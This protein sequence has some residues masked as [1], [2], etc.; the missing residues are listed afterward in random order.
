MLP[1][2]QDGL[3]MKLGLSSSICALPERGLACLQAL[4]FSPVVIP[5]IFCGGNASG[6]LKRFS[7]C[8][9]ER[10]GGEQT[11]LTAIQVPPLPAL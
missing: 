5:A 7:G 9:A 10:T 11:S 4:G 2:P 1:V 3:W 6:Q 8:F